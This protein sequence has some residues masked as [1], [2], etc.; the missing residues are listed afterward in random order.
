MLADYE[1]LDSWLVMRCGR[2]LDLPPGFTPRGGARDPSHML[3]HGVP[4]DAVDLGGL[5]VGISYR[6]RGGDETARMVRL[7]RA[8]LVDGDGYVTA[9]CELRRE[10]R[11]FRFS[12]IV[13]LVDAQ[14]GEVVTDV[15]A[16][17]TELGVRE[18]DPNR[19]AMWESIRLGMRVLM[20]LA[21]SD[22]QVTEDEVQNVVLYADRRA[23]DF[24]IMLDEKDCKRVIHI[25]ARLRPDLETAREAL[26][27]ITADPAHARI[28]VRAMR[29]LSM[30]DDLVCV[31]ENAF[32]RDLGV[33]H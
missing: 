12:G 4:R 13:Q 33:A 9:F 30:A 20:G 3:V 10:P 31:A 7:R 17:M 8:W 24:G 22:G 6:D 32:F 1:A 15:L 21:V 27:E 28:V 5:A 26:R 16:F 18:P 14:T 29:A 19:R 23:E 25:A 2:P 11:L